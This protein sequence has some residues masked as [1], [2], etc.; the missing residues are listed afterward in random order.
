VAVSSYRGGM[1][2]SDFFPAKVDT[3]LPQRQ[4][5]V[6]HCPPSLS[7]SSHSIFA[8]SPFLRERGRESECVCVCVCVRRMY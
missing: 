2:G 5:E 6:E 1:D 7:L 8:L 4:E 3:L